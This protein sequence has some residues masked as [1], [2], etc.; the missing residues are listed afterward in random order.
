[1]TERRKFW[2]ETWRRNLVVGLAG[3][4]AVSGALAL[5]VRHSDGEGQRQQF[6]VASYACPDGAT[7]RV[8][9]IEDTPDQF[10]PAADVSDATVSVACEDPTGSEQPPVAIWQGRHRGAFEIIVPTQTRYPVEGQTTEDYLYVRGAVAHLTPSLVRI[11]PA[12]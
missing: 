3:S 10:A 9:K 2:Q 11:V 12:G 5:V 8:T 6:M 1:M 4:L 7:L